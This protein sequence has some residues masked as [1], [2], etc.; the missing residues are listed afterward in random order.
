MTDPGNVSIRDADP[1]DGRVTF[2]EQATTVAATWV[3]PRDLTMAEAQAI[4]LAMLGAA[5]KAL[6]ILDGMK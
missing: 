2:S 3:A 5:K 6:R 4:H 1:P